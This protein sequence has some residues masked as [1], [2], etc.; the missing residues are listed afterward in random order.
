MIVEVIKAIDSY[1]W[2]ANHIG[3]RFEVEPFDN[4]GY[5]IIPDNGKWI[6]K[7]D[8]IE[9]KKKSLNLRN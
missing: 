3:E 4:I 8:A 7:D 1:V 2:Y 5:G 9:I 6:R